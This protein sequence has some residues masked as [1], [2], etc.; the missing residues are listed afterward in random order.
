[1]YPLSG[2]GDRLPDWGT[3][4]LYYKTRR[5]SILKEMNQGRE[6]AVGGVRTNRLW[7]HRKKM[8][9]S[10]RHVAK[11]LGHKSPARVSDYERGRGL[12]NLQTVLKL[13]TILCATVDTLY[14]DLY[15]ETKQEVIERRD[16]RKPHQL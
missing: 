2:R 3:S 14:K 15:L 8:G 12:P 9:Y 5:N 1:M 7:I 4:P 16:N 13:Q 10:Q 6:S 11:L